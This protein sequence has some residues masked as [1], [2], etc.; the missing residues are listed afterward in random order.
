MISIPRAPSWF[1]DRLARYAEEAG[2]GLSS[3]QL[4][5]LRQHAEFLFFWNRV[6]N[7]TAARDWEELITRHYIDALV[8]AHRW[9]PR[10]G[11]MLDIGSGAGFPG[12]PIKILSPDLDVTLCE[13]R[14]RKASF[15]KSFISYAKL[16]KIRVEQA[17]WQEVLEK[18][19]C[20]FHLITWRAI[21]IGLED[22]LKIMH[23]GV[24]EGGIVAC[25]TTP[26][27][28]K[29]GLFELSAPMAKA[30]RSLE[31]VFGKRVASPSVFLYS[32]PSRIERAVVIF[33]NE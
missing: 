8:V 13:V 24:T 30:K 1:T 6:T 5:L 2:V 12:V 23:R 7:L 11:L 21:K 15:L 20:K 31:E 10:S 18:A 26:S 28:L 4:E 29:T 3:A 9:L 22:V 16:Q 19:G 17:S 14:R 27:I 33:K 32:L 25:W